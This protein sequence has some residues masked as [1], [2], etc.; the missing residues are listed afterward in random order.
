MSC[1]VSSSRSLVG[2]VVECKLQLAVFIHH[3]GPPFN[4]LV[5]EVTTHDFCHPHAFLFVVARVYVTF[6][7]CAGSIPFT[8]QI[9]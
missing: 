1:E 2:L 6:M 9:P 5:E 7:L 3:L 8:E 4:N